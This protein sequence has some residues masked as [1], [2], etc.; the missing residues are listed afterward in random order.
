M[1]LEET[2]RYRNLASRAGALF[3]ALFF[4][5]ALDGL[6]TYLRE[7][8]NL[9]HL[10]AG[11]SL[12]V[13]GSMR[14][15]T[16]D[17]L[18]YHSSSERVRLTFKDVQPGF[19]MG[20]LMWRGVITISPE[21]EPGEVALSVSEK[22][23]PSQKP[24]SVFVLKIYPDRESYRKASKSFAIRFLGVSP[25][26]LFGFFFPLTLIAFGIVYLL[27]QKK[28]RLLVQQ[29]KAEI[30]RVAEEDGVL[31]VAFGLGTTHG[32]RPGDRPAVLDE[33]GKPVGKI[34]VKE[35]YET[36]STATVEPECKLK[37]G[38]VVSLKD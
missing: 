35:T 1:N 33:A 23:A 13:T 6:I 17:S 20:G 15:S 37:M 3:C 10:F 7:P 16:I 18:Q 30:Y 9:F 21:T 36:D 28:D 38:Y 4:L 32:V 11:E 8:Q 29:G 26:V 24:L 34:T 2:T 12:S 5:A 31:V 14:E 19:W 25:W 27:S 22:G